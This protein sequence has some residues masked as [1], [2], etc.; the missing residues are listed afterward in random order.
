MRAHSPEGESQ[1]QETESCLPKSAQ[2]YCAVL[3]IPGQVKPPDQLISFMG[4]QCK[5]L[6]EAE[7]ELQDGNHQERETLALKERLCDSHI[8]GYKYVM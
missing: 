3:A 1:K 7:L 2:S 8:T 4:V 6:I 5:D